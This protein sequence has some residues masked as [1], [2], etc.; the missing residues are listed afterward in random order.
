VTVAYLAPGP[1]SHMQAV[2]GGAARAAMAA[3]FYQ[4]VLGG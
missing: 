3:K 1:S 2:V 4:V